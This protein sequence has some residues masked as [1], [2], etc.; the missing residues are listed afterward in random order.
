[1]PL[2]GRRNWL[3]V[4]G[5]RAVEHGGVSRVVAV[6]GGDGGLGRGGEGQVKVLRGY[7][8]ERGRHGVGCAVGWLGAVVWGSGGG[9]GHAGR[10]GH[11]L[12]CG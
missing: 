5:R 11:G 3:G 9:C 7:L 4:K 12:R 6:C 2:V 1:M 8:S 10:G